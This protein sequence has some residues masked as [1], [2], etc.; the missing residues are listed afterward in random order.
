MKLWAGLHL[1]VPCGRAALFIV[2]CKDAPPALPEMSDF[3]KG[4]PLC[5][6]PL[7]LSPSSRNVLTRN[8]SSSC[9]ALVLFRRGL[10]PHWAFLSFSPSVHF[11]APATGFPP[12]LLSCTLKMSPPL[13][14]AAPSSPGLLL[15]WFLPP[16]QH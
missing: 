2:L 15:S 12:Q 5:L 7:P 6:Q 10:S 14:L 11:E 13:A 9:S 8:R 16:P 3:G 1:Q 4:W